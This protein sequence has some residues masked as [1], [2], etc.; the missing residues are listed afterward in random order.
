MRKA[1]ELPT[2]ILPTESDTMVAII[3]A[4]DEALG[5]IFMRLVEWI[6]LTGEGVQSRS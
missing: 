4:F 1:P 6:L 2:A 3:D 5:K